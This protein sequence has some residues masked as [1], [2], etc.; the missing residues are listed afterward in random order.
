MIQRSPARKGGNGSPGPPGGP[1]G[2]REG[3]EKGAFRDVE[4]LL[5]G[6]C[7]LAALVVALCLTASSSRPDTLG[8]VL[9]EAEAAE[10]AGRNSPLT[11]YIFLSPNADFPREG[12]IQKITIHHMAGNLSLEALG[13][14]FSQRD[15]RSSASY[16]VDSQGRVGLYVEEGNRPW[17]SGNRENDHQAVTIEVANEEIGGEW[18]VSGAAYEA[19]LALCADVCQRNGIPAL[20]YTGDETGNLTTHNM[21]NP[22]TEC[23]GPYLESRMAEI[24][25]G[26][27]RR[28]EALRAEEDE[29]P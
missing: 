10:I 19:V 17:T 4:A 7:A 13:D 24:A 28:L 29:N 23:P 18:R 1:A 25:A 16:G 12:E 21:F 9:T 27:N 22:E 8:R 26:V 11:E 5:A 20:T 6:F 2:K 3:E 15:R 14:L